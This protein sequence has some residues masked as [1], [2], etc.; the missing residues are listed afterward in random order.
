[1][2]PLVAIAAKPMSTKDVQINPLA[3]S[4]NE[5]VAYF[6]DLYGGNTQ[7]ALKVMGCES[8]G[9]SNSIGDGGRSR[10]VFQFQKSTFLRMEKAFGEKLNYNS[11]LDQIKLATWALSKKE[12]ASEWSTYRAI[13]NGGKY[14]FYS[15]QLQRHFI[16]RCKI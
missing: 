9:D 11:T 5:Q 10:G 3:L 2:L 6:S 15:R 14:S 4:V 13:V 1:M 12:Y 7:I 8:S 16:V